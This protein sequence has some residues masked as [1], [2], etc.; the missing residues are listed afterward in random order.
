M[1]K[2]DVNQEKAIEIQNACISYASQ[3]LEMI[4]PRSFQFFVASI[5]YDFKATGV[6]IIEQILRQTI[7]Q[8][9]SSE[10][11]S[12]LNTEFYE[13]AFSEIKSSLQ[14]E[15]QTDLL[16]TD[17][18]SEKGKHL[19]NQLKEPFLISASR[20]RL[21][22]LKRFHQELAKDPATADPQVLSN[23][24]HA[25]IGHPLLPSNEKA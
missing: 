22:K 13:K 4:T 25:I 5:S 23:Q 20:I 16:S 2:L 8:C 21:S 10:D 1:I 15:Y 6:E 19:I 11:F 14:L 24:L 12:Q 7:H 17:K 18:S 3:S 9:H